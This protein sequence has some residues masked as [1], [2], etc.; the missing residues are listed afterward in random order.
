MVKEGKVH[1][2]QGVDISIDANTIC[3]HGDGKHALDY[4]KY[5]SSALEEV[6][7]KGC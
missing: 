4:A 1:S 5:I 6:K 7:Y 2:L 3:I